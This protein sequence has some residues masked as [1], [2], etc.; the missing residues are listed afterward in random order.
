M[1]AL[2]GSG[3]A[4][5][6]LQGQ[7]A[8]WSLLLT[9]SAGSPLDTCRFVL[10]TYSPRV[11]QRICPVLVTLL[12]DK[13]V[14][15]FILNNC[16]ERYIRLPRGFGDVVKVWLG[17]DCFRILIKYSDSYLKEIKKCKYVLSSKIFLYI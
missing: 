11:L 16:P 1:D 8:G 10:A 9:V 12:P 17:Y 6:S 15:I 5:Q 13:G 7:Q 4:M 14:L 3:V 2:A